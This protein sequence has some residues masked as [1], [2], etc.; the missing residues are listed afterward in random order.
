MILSYPTLTLFVMKCDEDVQCPEDGC[1]CH[2][3]ISPGKK[4]KLPNTTSMI[5]FSGEYDTEAHDEQ[6]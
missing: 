2:L 4:G 1:T 3:S 6:A 5:K